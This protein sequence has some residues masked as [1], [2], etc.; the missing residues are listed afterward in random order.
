MNEELFVYWT[1][2]LQIG[3]ELGNWGG[4]PKKG[5]VARI[6]VA[7]AVVAGDLSPCEEV[8]KRKCTLRGLL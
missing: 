4:D 7:R 1:V 6:V 3:T 2:D 8:E 5:W